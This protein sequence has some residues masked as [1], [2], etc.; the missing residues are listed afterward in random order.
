MEL[1]AIQKAPY[2]RRQVHIYAVLVTIKLPFYGYG[3]GRSM[4][5][6]TGVAQVRVRVRASHRYG[7]GHITAIHNYVQAYCRYSCGYMTNMALRGVSYVVAIYTFGV[8]FHTKAHVRT[9]IC[10]S[11]L[12]F[13]CCLFQMWISLSVLRTSCI[14][15]HMRRMSTRLASQE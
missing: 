7:Y 2:T 5:T 1:H 13:N 6:G 15:V 9:S 12:Q 8:E 3:Y 10:P 4:G 14:S 11:V